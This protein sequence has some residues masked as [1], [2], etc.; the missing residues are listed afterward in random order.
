M[1]TSGGE[2]GRAS[3]S[4]G[5]PRTH[6]VVEALRRAA[7][8]V[9]LAVP[10]LTEPDGQALAN[11]ADAVVLVAPVGDA[12]FKQLEESLVEAARVHARVLGV[13]AVHPANGPPTTRGQA[14]PG[15]PEVVADVQQPAA[16]ATWVPS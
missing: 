3:E 9:V 12:T 2:L 1:L 10:P 16:P 8:V 13:A 15:Q 14:G 5:G 11:V 4:Y 6:R 7:E